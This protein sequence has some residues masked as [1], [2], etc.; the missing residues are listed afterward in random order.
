MTWRLA[1]PPVQTKAANLLTGTSAMLHG[2]VN[3]K[4]NGP[5]ATGFQFG[6][7]PALLGAATLAA[8]SVPDGGV[9][10]GIS[11]A[12]TNLTPGTVYYFRASAG[13]DSGLTG[14]I[15]SFQTLTFFQSWR[16]LHFGTTADA[17][18]AAGNADPDG[19]GLSNLMEF[20]VGSRPRTASPPP[21]TYPWNGTHVELQYARN[22]HA[23]ASGCLFTVE[24]SDE[25]D[26]TAWS[27]EGV[28]HTLISSTGTEQWIIAQ[29]PSGPARRFA[30]LRV[31]LP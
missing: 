26:A 2:T 27:H 22:M 14:N 31:W 6:T 9:A 4:N 3:P 23:I 1:F 28:E 16:L 15:L 29:I 19:D 11:A 13:A 12:L 5:I 25:L 20:D 21:V 7:N 10:S 17:G 24:W 8:G 18:E 30:R